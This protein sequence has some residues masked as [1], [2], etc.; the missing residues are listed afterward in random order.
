[1][2][3]PKWGGAPV[4]LWDVW[5]EQGHPVRAT[6]S[7]MGPLLL[8]RLLN[9]NETQ[10]GVLALAFK[11]ADDNQLLLLDLKDLRALLQFVGDNAAKFKTQYG[12]ISPASIGAI[13]R[14]LLQ[15]E[16]QG[17]D[18]FF[19]E[20]MLDIDDLMQTD[21]QGRGVVNVLAAD[22]LMQNPRLYS[23]FLLWLLAELFENLPEVGDRD[24][25]K[26][27]FFFDEAHL[28]FSEA[29]PALIEKVEQVVRLIRSKGVG[30]YFVTQNP[31]D[32][33]DKVLGQLGNR[34]QHALR[35]FTPRDQKAVKS[36]A[37][38]MRANPK[39]DAEKAILELGVGEALV[40][41]LD[42]KG[43][44]GITQR[45]W[46]FPP[47]SHIGPITPD[48][49]KKLVADSLVAG[50]YDKTVDRESAF[51][52]LKARAG[53]GE[54]RVANRRRAGPPGN[55]PAGRAASGA[56]SRTSCSARPARAAAGAKA[57]S[58]PRRRAPRA[59]WAARS[60]AKSRAACSAR[61]WAAGAADLRERRRVA[62]AASSDGADSDALAARPERRRGAA[63]VGRST[64]IC[65]RS[66]R[67]R[68]ST[69][70]RY[71]TD[72]ASALHYAQRAFRACDAPRVSRRLCALPVLIFP[73]WRRLDDGTLHSRHSQ[74]DVGMAESRQAGTRR[75][76]GATACIRAGDRRWLRR[77]RRPRP[78]RHRDRAA[79]LR[80]QSPRRKAARFHP[81]AQAVD[82]EDRRHRPGCTGTR[83]RRC[84]P[85]RIRRRAV[86][87]RCSQCAQQAARHRRAWST[88][89]SRPTIAA[90]AQSRLAPV[91]DRS[92][93]VVDRADEGG[94][95]AEER[96]DRRTRSRGSPR[97]P[98]SRSRNAR[99]LARR[100]A[101]RRR[102][103]RRC[104]RA[105][106][107]R[108]CNA[109]PRTPTSRTSKSIAARRT[110]AQPSDPMYASQ[111]NLTRSGR[112]HRGAARVGHHDRRRE[113][114]DRDPRHRRA[115]ASRSRRSRVGGYDFVAD[116]RFSNDGD[117]RD[118]DASDPG[119]FV[120]TAESTT[121]GR[122]LQGCA[123]GNSTW[124]GTMVA[125][126][127]GAA[128]NNGSGMSGVNWTSPL[129][130]VRVHGQ[131]RRRAFRCRRRH[132]L[133]S[134][135]SGAGR[136][137]EYDARARH[138]P[139]PRR[140]R[141]LRSD[142]AKRRHGCDRATAR[143]S[144]PRPGTTTTTSRTIGPRT[145][146]ASSRSPRRRRTVRARSTRTPDRASQS[147]RRAA[148]SA[149]AFRCCATRGTTSADP[150]GYGYGQ[151]LGS[152]LAAPH[153]AGIASLVLAMD[154]NLTP[155]EVRGLI[156]SNARAFPV[157]ATDPCSTSTCGAGI[158]DAAIT[159]RGSR[160][161]DRS[162]HRRLVGR[163]RHRRRRPHPRRPQCRL[164]R[165]NSPLADIPPAG[166]APV[167]GGW[168]AKSPEELNRLLKAAGSP[169][170]S[171]PNPSSATR[172]AGH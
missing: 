166:L 55:A 103:K 48:E 46:I 155:A 44:P 102:S 67:R 99:T 118:A 100:V 60:P 90:R 32:I 88:P 12:N 109:S 164:R 1:M 123:A 144:S 35:A 56:A 161:T 37:E 84:V 49:R 54:R 52:L 39:L 13:Q 138:Q 15:I 47:G 42:A 36:V 72:N 97:S 10:E 160:R 133:G 3:E 28:L 149:E 70:T 106:S 134:R 96:N 24:K 8:A 110:Q 119:D 58:R 80:R 156:E 83:C 68:Y 85:V 154:R 126:T 147:P 74:G 127:L 162:C 57:W 33:P 41:L 71:A 40:S 31:L 53:A 116:A 139:E 169:G 146:T 27:V 111:W 75:S 34:V 51:E 140:A 129:L 18:R 16:Q 9:L 89:I 163:R 157:V 87:G 113:C 38:T 121:P 108:C 132:P 168:R 65:C 95:D 122:P 30:V 25:P 86:A 64:D 20:P 73:S 26:L 170:R 143:S 130:N 77:S 131:V 135:A 137:C 148:A 45:V 128:V 23:T 145:A 59:R 21:A 172:S 93:H 120:T 171:A 101:G 167:P 82:R 136:A 61:C 98:V 141:R 66:D 22:K 114:A 107:S 29:P 153:V 105:P 2:P 142:P 165:S 4:T 158:A 124:H 125:G 115:A 63:F 117:G 17:G 152:S 14:G 19:G 151:Q 69:Y 62:D 43:T 91:R 81:T 7:D 50:T 159:V 79:L 150:N 104:R 6:I 112:R 78:R 76:L 11:I 94:V 92:G 5:G